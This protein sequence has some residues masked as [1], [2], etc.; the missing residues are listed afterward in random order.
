MRALR[1]VGPRTVAG[2]LRCCQGWTGL[3]VAKARDRRPSILD[4]F[5]P[6][7]HQRWNEGC[8][9]V[10]QLHAEIRG[11]GYR[12]GYGTVRDYLQ[13]FRALAAAPP[14]TPAPPKV[15]TTHS[16][17]W[18]RRSSNWN[19]SARRRRWNMYSRRRRALR[20]RPT[21][22]G[23]AGLATGLDDSR[24]PAEPEGNPAP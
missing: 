12:G 3:L 2:G 16:G 11:Q 22:R 5:K 6:Y 18:K 8:T 4:D 14:A 15:R 24:G 13:P 17:T 19:R 10:W 21:P 7:L 9:N 23:A 1:A 20:Q